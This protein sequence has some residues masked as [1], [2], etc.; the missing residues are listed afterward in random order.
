MDWL[1]VNVCTCVNGDLPWTFIP[2]KMYLC[3]LS[4]IFRTDN[5]SQDKTVTENERVTFSM[6]IWESFHL[7]LNSNCTVYLV[8]SIIQ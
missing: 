2:S 5:G 7:K 6:V 4:S 8:H 1:G 3:H